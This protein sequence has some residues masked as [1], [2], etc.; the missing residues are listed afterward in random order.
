V[1]EVRADGTIAQLTTDAT[2]KWYYVEETTLQQNIDIIYRANSASAEALALFQLVVASEDDAENSWFDTVAAGDYIKL[3]GTSVP[4]GT[5]DVP[6]RINVGVPGEN[7]VALLDVVI[8]PEGLG[9][10]ISTT[11]T[12][13]W[14]VVNNGAYLDVN[15][16]QTMG[17]DMTSVGKFQSGTVRVANG[18]KARDSAWM[19]WPLGSNSAFRVLYGGSIAVGKGDRDGHTWVDGYTGELASG[20]PYYPAFEGWLIAP[21]SESNTKAVWGG[22]VSSGEEDGYGF[23]DA[24]GT[25]VVIYGNV[26]IKKTAGL[27]YNV[28]LVAGTTL[29]IDDDA[30]LSPLASVYGQ[31]ADT[32]AMPGLGVAT[33]LPASKIILNGSGM[34]AKH[35][36]NASSVF[37]SGGEGTY[38]VTG[39]VPIEGYEVYEGS[40]DIKFYTDWTR[41][42]QP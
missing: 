38:T 13:T 24:F 32:G 11:Y 6:A 12:Y 16:T 2:S 10:D 41:Q 17:G 7:N 36:D 33:L 20:H 42:S 1:Q 21:S 37:S 14:I 34:I 26:T 29:T 19:G 25:S 3:A 18:G 22:Q 23:L 4:T 35:L 27:I 40:L 5:S 28:L 39:S 9:A 15:A 31:P 30:S 8:P